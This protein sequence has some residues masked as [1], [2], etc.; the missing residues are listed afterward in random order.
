MAIGSCVFVAHGLRR[1]NARLQPWR[2][3]YEL[4]LRF[5]A[6]QPVVIVTDCDGGESDEEWASNVRV[7]SS[8]LLSPKRRHAL[9][10]LINSFNPGQIWWSTTPRSVVYLSVWKRLACPVMVL[11]TCPLY[12]W[13]LLLRAFAHGVPWVELG[14]LFRQRVVPRWMFAKLLRSPV[15]ARVVTQSGNNRDLLIA[16]GVPA[17]KIRHI[18]VGI[19]PEDRGKVSAPQ[20]SEARAMLGVPENATVFLY[21]GAVRRIRGIYALLNA[22]AIATVGNSE[23]FL[24]VLARGADE[25]LCGEVRAYCEKLGIVDRVKLIGG[26]LTREQVWASIEAC[27]VVAQPFVVVPSD[28]PIAILEA[29]ARVKPVIASDVDGIPELVRGRGSVVDPLNS[30][31]LAQALLKFATS[32][33]YRQEMAGEAKLFMD[34]YPDWDQVGA[35]ALECSSWD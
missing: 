15:V 8:R 20:I 33:S 34:T 29:M 3:I 26:W 10:V 19:D 14:A 23:I 1:D 5:A 11:V 27:D 24:G 13:S 21:L 18:P 16:A 17:E 2:Y 25:Q 30:Q 7:I 28:V 12:P 35:L 32:E 31:A 4:A 6:K 9:G 22:F